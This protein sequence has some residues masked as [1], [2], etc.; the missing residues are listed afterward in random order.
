MSQRFS[1]IAAGLAT[2]TAFFGSCCALP[3]LLVSLGVGG[4]AFANTLA[5]YRPYFVGATILLLA[6]AFYLVYGR[7]QE[8]SDD[9]A[10]EPKAIRRTKILLW[11]TTGLAFLFFIGPGLIA[12]LFLS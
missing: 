6:V 10:C 8:C 9:K 5:L 3:L 12:R 1:K 2:F 11:I 4:M 7:R